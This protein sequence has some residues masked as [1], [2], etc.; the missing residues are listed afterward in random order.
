MHGAVAAGQGAQP[1]RKPSTET[2]KVI[3]S[4]A[5]NNT[6]LSVF[7]ERKVLGCL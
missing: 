2:A 7:A 1:R 3:G 5:S 6:N 4:C